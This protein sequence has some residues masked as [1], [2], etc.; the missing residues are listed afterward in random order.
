LLGG[1]PG[2]QQNF[3]AYLQDV[4]KGAEVEFP[5]SADLPRPVVF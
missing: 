3:V 4:P 5:R 2:P 1:R